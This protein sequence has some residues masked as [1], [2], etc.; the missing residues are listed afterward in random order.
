MIGTLFAEFISHFFDD[1]N[2]PREDTVFRPLRKPARF[3]PIHFHLTSQ[4]GGDEFAG[5]GGGGLVALGIRYGL[6]RNARNPFS[7]RRSNGVKTPGHNLQ[8]RQATDVEN[9]KT[10]IS[11]LRSVPRR[12]ALAA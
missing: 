2:Q 9:G 1:A 8:R 11:L 6:S 3:R 10:M 7:V 12:I 5:A 4:R